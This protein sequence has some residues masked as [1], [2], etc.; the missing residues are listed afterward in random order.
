M[1]RNRRIHSDLVGHPDG[2]GVFDVA[3][4]AEM[5]VEVLAGLEFAAA[6]R[7]QGEHDFL[8]VGS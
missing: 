5:G 2:L 1:C 6:E 4:I 8:Q 7:D 3:G